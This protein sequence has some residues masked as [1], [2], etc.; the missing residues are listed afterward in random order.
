MRSLRYSESETAFI[1]LEETKCAIKMSSLSLSIVACFA[2][3]A[4][5][6]RKFLWG[7]SLKNTV[8][9]YVYFP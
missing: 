5:P 2:L 8:F 1:Q 9:L 4:E 6:S 7:F 3:H